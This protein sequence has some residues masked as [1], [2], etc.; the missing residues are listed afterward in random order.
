MSTEPIQPKKYP[1]FY[2]Q[3]F[4][5][6]GCRAPWNVRQLENPSPED[7]LAIMRQLREEGNLGARR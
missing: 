6:Y 2:R 4:K 5:E 7:A 1:S 3:A